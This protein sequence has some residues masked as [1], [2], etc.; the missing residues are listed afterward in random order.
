MGLPELIQ[1]GGSV[2]DLLWTPFVLGGQPYNRSI[3]SFGRH[4]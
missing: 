1:F 2:E 4:Y 3:S